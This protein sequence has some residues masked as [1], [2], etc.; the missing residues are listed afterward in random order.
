MY[1]NR[2]N[3]TSFENHRSKKAI[4]NKKELSEDKQETEE[5]ALET[6]KFKSFSSIFYGELTRNWLSINTI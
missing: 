2:I 1:L 4:D 6:S 5:N 3:N